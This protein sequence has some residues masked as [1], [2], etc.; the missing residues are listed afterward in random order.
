MNGFNGKKMKMSEALELVKI[1][2]LAQEAGRVKQVPTLAGRPGIG[3]T[4]SLRALGK[5]LGYELIT[6]Q[7]SAVAPEEFSGIPDFLDA[8]EEF[9]KKYS[10]NKV[11]GAKFTRWSVPE[12]V[13]LANYRAEKIKQEGGKGVVVL[14]DD[15]HAADPALERYMFNLFLDKTVG[16]YKLADNVLV[17]AAMNDSDE[18]GFRG[19]NAAVLD[20][21][22]VYSVEFN[23]DDWY[24][25]MG[26][27]LDPMVA[28]Y[29]RNH[30]ERMTADETTD[31]VSPSPRSWT[32]LSNLV[33]FAREKGVK[34]SGSMLRNMAAARVGDEAAAELVKFNITYEKFNF[35]KMIKK[36]A[37]EITVPSDP[38][39]QV[40]FGTLVRYAKTEEEGKT[41]AELIETKGD[42][43]PVFVSELINEIIILYNNEDF[44]KRKAFKEIEAFLI[45]SQH[46]AVA[47]AFADVMGY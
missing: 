32:E 41:I 47:E 17:C 37:K 25:I 8:P 19:F 26:A 11:G 35:E 31:K 28:S 6:V 21:L 5:K 24:K 22:A 4:E 2:L 10:I 12:L 15:I 44:R 39:D 38:I 40:M 7:L 42:Q 34:I 9:S 27:T 23:F 1:E 3:K 45:K 29:L 46:P 20:R 36:P 18:A 13:A 33:K 14:F 16:Q 30:Q 43:A